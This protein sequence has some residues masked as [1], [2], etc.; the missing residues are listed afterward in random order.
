MVME[1]VGGI[2]T[3]TLQGTLELILKNLR[4]TIFWTF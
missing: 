3:E 4:E 1:S 2:L